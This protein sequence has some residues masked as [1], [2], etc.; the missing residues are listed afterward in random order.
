MLVIALFL[1]LKYD[2]PR[3]RHCL[4]HDEFSL[5]LSLLLREMTRS[6]EYSSFSLRGRPTTKD[7]TNLWG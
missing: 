5:H 6:V 4:R 3:L 1:P 2:A 7:M